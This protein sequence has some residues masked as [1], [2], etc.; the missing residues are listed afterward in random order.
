MSKIHRPDKNYIILSELNLSSCQ[1]Q[2]YLKSNSFLKFWTFRSTSISSNCVLN[3]FHGFSFFVCFA[4]NTFSC[5]LGR[6][7]A[8]KNTSPHGVIS[9]VKYLSSKTLILVIRRMFSITLLPILGSSAN[10]FV[11]HIFFNLV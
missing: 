4:V 3:Y 10:I 2:F 11:L 7:H 5:F 6:R 9:A 1:L 8:K